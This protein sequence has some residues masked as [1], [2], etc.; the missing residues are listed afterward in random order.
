[1]PNELQRNKARRWLRFGLLL[2]GFL[3]FFWLSGYEA[4]VDLTDSWDKESQMEEAVRQLEDENDRI[5]TAI[6]ELAPGGKAVEQIARQD[7]GWAKP[8]EIVVKIPDKE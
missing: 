7:L 2:L 1:M 8:G 4:L 3:G 5:E 6:K